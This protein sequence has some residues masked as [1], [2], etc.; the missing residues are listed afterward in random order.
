[1]DAVQIIGQGFGVL[2]DVFGFITFQIR[3]RK[4]V[5]MMQIAVTVT[6]CI[7]YILI[8]VITAFAMN[9]FGLVRNIVYL[10][11]EKKWLSSPVIPIVFSVIMGLIGALTWKGWYSVFLVV[12]LTVNTYCMSFRDPEN[13]RRSILVTSP[14]MVVYNI[15]VGSIGGTVYESIV[16]VSSA[17]GLIRSAR[18]K[19]REALA[20]AND[21]DAAIPADAADASADTAA[22]TNVAAGSGAAHE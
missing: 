15:F 18:R 10:N 8:G 2:A 7:H 21:A 20:A 4:G 1:M 3:S 11:R 19:K 9:A 16:I 5:M 13:I 12:G 14:L 22:N 6:F 17:I